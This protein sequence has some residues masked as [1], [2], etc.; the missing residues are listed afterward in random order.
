[1]LNNEQNK[2]AKVQFNTNTK[3]LLKALAKASTL[4]QKNS[5]NEVH[6][7]L[8]VTIKQSS[9][10]LEALGSNIYLQ[11]TVAS[12]VSDYQDDVRFL[13]NPSLLQESLTL[14]KDEIVIFSLE[15]ETGVLNLKTSK[16]KQQFRLNNH[17]LSDFLVPEDK[18]S[19]SLE[20]EF[21]ILPQDFQKSL[22]ITNVC[23]GLPKLISDPKFL[24]ICFNFETE[25]ILSM[26]ATDK[27]R[28]A[29]ANTTITTIKNQ[30]S[31][32]TGNI[33]LFNPKTLLAISSFIDDNIDEPIVFRLTTD[34]A[35][36][37]VNSNKIAV[38]YSGR[39]YHN[40]KRIIPQSFGYMYQVN[41]Q[42]LKETLKQVMVIAKKIEKNKAITLEIDS[43]QN[44]ASLSSKA[45]DGSEIHTSLPI[46]NYNA[47]EGAETE[48][49]VQRFNIDSLLDITNQIDDQMM[50]FEQQGNRVIISPLNRKDDLLYLASGLS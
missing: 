16:T 50:Q 49:W 19:A 47:G 36:V 31:A 4:L 25:G 27:F 13:F 18:T 38:Q 20:L 48:V 24:S 3:D 6:S 11:A 28:L 10:L 46:H 17:L 34:F 2:I 15:N 23:V 39:E 21:G 45:P 26:I 44:I 35:W 42:E 43:V 7:L 30:T 29:V 9:L 33:Y 1:M 37:Q 22:R 40:I 5:K 12:A 14:I 8:K 41:T 32:D